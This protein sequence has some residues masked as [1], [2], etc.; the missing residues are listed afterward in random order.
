[1]HILI[2]DD[3]QAQRNI[4]ADILKD[5]GY[6]TDLAENGEVAL[7]KFGAN[8]YAIVLTDLKMPGKDGLDVLKHIHNSD[9]D[10]Q[11]IIMTAFGTIPGAVNAI[12]IGAYDYLTK[13]FKKDDLLQVVDR[14]AEKVK[15]LKENARLKNEIS[16]RYQYASI[17]GQSPEM[18]QI[19]SMIERVA[20]VDATVLITGKSGTGKELVARAVHYNGNRKEGP[21]VAL[22]CGAI[23]ET[24]I[25]SELFGH[26][27]GAFTGAA[28]TYMG[29]FEQAQGGTIF[30]DEIGTM[31]LDL[32][33]RLLRVLQ[34]KKVQKLGSNQSIDLD[35]RV[36]AA[37]NENLEELINEKKFRSDLYHR[38]NVFS[39]A[40][41]SLKD[42]FQDIPLLVRH[43]LEK[44]AD[45]Y[46]KEI[47]ALSPDALNK[48]E[49][50]PF[51]GNVRE[52]ENII[53]KTIILTDHNP[54][55]ADDLMLPST[56]PQNNNVKEIDSNGSLT[57]IEYKLI[58]DALIESNGSIKKASEALGISYKT[59]QYRMKKFNMH[60]ND[61]R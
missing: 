21:F 46:K 30:L 35:V 54:I 8:Q 28:K 58:S 41:P 53:E 38:L 19:F 61:F 5:A 25:E 2:V 56:K 40:L 10:T 57:D 14:A 49:K 51:P 20:K 7:R 60:K 32:Q 43:F 33:I 55:L 34:E 26:E 12:K 42:R 3:E 1:M 17:I 37:S 50:Y 22:N 18:R 24:L 52:L 13:P 44:Y 27:K 23:P 59:L 4:L 16:N 48:L 47:P 45:Q 31:R 9:Q 6:K 11:V 36:I 39:I 15:L 29:K